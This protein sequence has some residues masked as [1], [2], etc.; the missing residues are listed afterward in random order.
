MNI[1]E[2]MHKYVTILGT[3]NFNVKQETKIQKKKLEKNPV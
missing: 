1:T 3:K 2:E